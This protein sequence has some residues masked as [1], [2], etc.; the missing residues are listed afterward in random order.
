MTTP[1][2][3]L[4]FCVI[5]ETA[6]FLDLAGDRYFRLPEAANA[7]FTA[8]L[9]NGVAL[10]PA[11]QSA[12]LD[13]FVSLAPLRPQG[14][15]IVTRQ[16]ADLRGCGFSPSLMARAL[17]E[18]RAIERRLAKRGLHMVLSEL[19]SVLCSRHVSR[20]FG[21]EHTALVK[22]FEDAGL[23]RSAVNRCLPRSIALARLMARSGC[24]C[25]VIIGVKLRPFA[26]HCWVQA[27]HFVLNESVEESAR[28]TPILIL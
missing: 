23:V 18:Q 16:A 26:A 15:G 10:A 8:S 24:A 12:G 11:L 22:A 25:Q 6:L 5:E 13:Q 19:R 20:P 14:S 17:W 1:L 7:A 4:S 27:G 21:A 2:P 3:T 9:F 28:Y